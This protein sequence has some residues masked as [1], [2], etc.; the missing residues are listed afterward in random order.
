MRIVPRPYQADAT[1]SIFDYFANNREGNP[2]VAMPTGTGKSVVIADF[3]DKV[4]GRYKNQKIMVLTHVKELIEQNHAKL[5]AMWPEAP[6]GIYSSGLNR[7]D[8][9]EPII[10]GGIASVNGKAPQFGH[11]D[12][13][14]IDEAHLVSPN[15][16]T[17]Y[18]TFINDLMKR[19]PYIRVIGLTA[20]PW[21][22]GKGHIADP[23]DDK[24]L[25]TH[26]CYDITGM[27]EFNKL[28]REGYLCT[29]IPK[30]TAL[31]V[32]LTAVNV[33][34][35]EFVGRAL[36]KAMD[37]QAITEAA[38][39]EAMEIGHDRNC[40]LVFAAG[41]EHAVHITEML[42]TL[43]ISAAAVHGGNKDYKMSKVQRRDTLAAFKAGKIKALVNNNVLTTGFDHP[44]IDFIVMLR[45]TMS[46]GLWVQMLGRGTRPFYAPGFDLTTEEG[47]ILAIENSPKRYCLVAD[48]GGN[49]RRLGPINDPCIPRKK[50]KKGGVAPVRTCEAKMPDGSYCDT[51]NHAAVRFCINCGYEFVFETKIELNASSENLIKNDL[52]IVEEFL[53]SHITYSNHIKVGA[54]PMMRVSYFCG[55]RKFTQHVCLEHEGFASKVGRDWW[56]ERAATPPPESTEVA[57]HNTNL[58]ACPSHIRVWVNKKYPEIMA[59]CFD[60]SNFDKTEPNHNLIPSGKVSGNILQLNTMLSLQ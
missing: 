54:P 59:C 9:Y 43:G 12:L 45:P 29:L 60:G 38:V 41:I 25:F 57:L 49:T 14:I 22:V 36:Q 6:A 23:E 50:G 34:G 2:I 56:R 17:M 42:N 53:V 58:L 30:K 20:T 18:Q 13:I 33:A 52:P 8:V 10:F 7:R 21:R 15:S 37:K 40:W 47:R 11:V 24:S 4:F 28:I 35:G 31:S 16:T 19:N 39:R 44:P 48:F 27:N 3:L 55:V 46:P 5:L 51:I 1:T 32:D 26:V